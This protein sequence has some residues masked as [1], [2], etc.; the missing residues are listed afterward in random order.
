MTRIKPDYSEEKAKR[1]VDLEKLIEAQVNLE[2][3]GPA[4]LPIITS[5]EPRV[6]QKHDSPC[7]L[8]TQSSAA[9]YRTTKENID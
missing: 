5:P 2:G 3:L 8:Y 6:H 1:A 9:L 4:C 7:P